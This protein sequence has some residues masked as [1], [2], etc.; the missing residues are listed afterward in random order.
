MKHGGVRRN[1]VDKYGNL[2]RAALRPKAKKF[3]AEAVSDRELLAVAVL[4][5][6]KTSIAF[7]FTGL[8]AEEAKEWVPLSLIVWEQQTD[9]SIQ[10]SIAMA[11][12][13]VALSVH[14]LTRSDS[15]YEPAVNW[16][17]IIS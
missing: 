4:H 1:E 3:T 13:Q 11:F 2:R 7:L 14:A 16:K 15:L 9:T 5:S 6:W 10:Y 12:N 17:L 8:T